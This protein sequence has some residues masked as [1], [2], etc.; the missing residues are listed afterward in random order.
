LRPVAQAIANR[1]YGSIEAFDPERRDMPADPQAPYVETIRFFDP[2]SQRKDGRDDEE[3]P[4]RG[5]PV[6]VK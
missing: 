6:R 1:L 2:P 5:K 3:S 4:P